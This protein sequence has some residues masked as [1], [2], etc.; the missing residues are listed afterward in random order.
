MKILNS[1]FASIIA[2]IICLVTLILSIF[3]ICSNNMNIGS[4]IITIITAILSAY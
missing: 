2:L 1:I 4:Y 3:T